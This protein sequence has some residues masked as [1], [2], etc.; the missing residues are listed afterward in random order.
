MP[1]LTSYLHI[2]TPKRGVQFDKQLKRKNEWAVSKISEIPLHTCKLNPSEA[3]Y[4]FSKSN[5]KDLFNTRIE[6]TKLCYDYDISKVKESSPCIDF[7]R[8]AQRATTIIGNPLIEIDSD[9]IHSAYKYLDKKLAYPQIQKYCPR[10]DKMYT[11]KECDR[12]HKVYYTCNAKLALLQL[13]RKLE[14]E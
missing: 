11:K 1:Q 4:S 14:I 13:R 10:D 9:K 6:S 8:R 5:R 12:T 7:T 2:K 3:S